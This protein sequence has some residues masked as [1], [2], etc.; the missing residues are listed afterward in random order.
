MIFREFDESGK[1]VGVSV[2]YP[3]LPPSANKIYSYHKGVRLTST[4]REYRER[5]KMHVSQYYLHQFGEMPMPNIQG[6][7]P[8]TGNAIDIRTGDPNLIFGLQL[9]FY[10]DTMTSWGDE[11]IYK[12]QR[13]KFRF[14][15]SDLSNR[16][17]FVEDCFKWSIGIDDSLTF[18][19]QQAKVHSPD[20]D[21][22]LLNYYTVP[23]EN[24]NVPRVDGE[25]M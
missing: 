22:V 6:L 14:S 5:F 18:F 20:K 9:Y 25:P 15:K 21:G 1:R 16:I 7:D 8:K 10:M 19:I 23:V 13:A 3:E 17:K 4:S 11:R 2:W 12:S 24:F